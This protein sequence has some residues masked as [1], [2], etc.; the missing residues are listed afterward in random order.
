MLACRLWF[1]LAFVITAVFTLS[2]AAPARAATVSLGVAQQH[3]SLIASDN[4][5]RSNQA[6]IAGNWTS[7]TMNLTSNH[8]VPASLGADGAA[9]YSGTT[10]PNDQYSKA[11][12]S[13][14][15]TAGA[16]HGVGLL[17]RRSTSA[18]T[19]YRLVVDHASTGNVTLSKAIAG[20]A[21]TLVTLT[22][23]WSDGDVWELRVMGTTLQIRR[24]DVQ[25]GA[26]VID[27]SIASGRAGVAYAAT[28]S[29]ASVDDWEGGA[30]AKA[31]PHEPAGFTAFMNTDFT[32]FPIDEWFSN[33]ATIVT[34]STAPVSS[35]FQVVQWEYETS[36]NAGNSPGAIY[37]EEVGHT[38]DAYFVGFHFKFSD[39]YSNHANG[40]SMWWP[41][42]DSASYVIVFSE[43]STIGVQVTVPDSTYNLEGNIANPTLAL[44]VWHQFEH[45]FQP[46]SSPTADDGIIRWWIDGVLCGDYTDIAWPGPSQD[47]DEWRYYPIWGGTGGHPAF[48]SYQWVDRIY[49]SQR[50]HR[51]HV[52]GDSLLATD[53][54]DRADQ[55]PLAGNWTATD[56]TPLD[57]VSNH[58]RPSTLV[59]D[60]GAYYSAIAWPDDQYSKANLSVRGTE[61]E[62][63]GVG[64]LVRQSATAVTHY[65]LVVDHAESGNVAIDKAIDGDYTNLATFT[66]EW[67]DGDEWE[68]R[69]VGPTLQ[70]FRNGNQVGTNITDYAIASGSAG[71]VYSSTETSAA[72][73]NWEGGSAVT[74]GPPEPVAT[75]IDP[76]VATTLAASTA[77]LY[78]GEHPVQTG[79]DSGTIDPVRVA[80]LRGRVID[81]SGTP[82][83]G[84]AVSFLDHP[85]FGQTL[86][87]A[88][89]G[90]DLAANGGGMLTLTYALT[91]YL[92]A[93][94]PV[95]TRGQ[96]YAP[97]F[98]V[99]LVPLDTAV[100][101]IAFSD[102]IEVARG[103]V[104]T[105]TNGARQ[106]TLLFRQGTT[107]ML[108][109]PDTTLTIDTLHVRATE[110]T[111]G[112]RGAQA[113]PAPLP[114]TVAYT[115]A[116]ELS[117]DEAV[118]AGATSVGFSL[119][120][121]FY[122]E[123]F[124][125]FPVGVPVPVGSYDRARGVWVPEDNGR[126]IKIL[127]TTGDTATIDADGDSLPDDSTQLAA[128]GVTV[129][130]Q[131][132]LAGLY[133]PGQTLWRVQTAHFTTMDFNYGPGLCTGAGCPPQ[134]PGPPTSI[135]QKDDCCEDGGSIVESQNQ[136]LGETIEVV[137]TPFSLN[138][139]SD[140]VPG[141]TSAYRLDIPLTGSFVASTVAALW[142]SEQVAGRTFLDS[143]EAAPD[144]STTFTW[145]GLDAYGRPM[146]GE[147]PVTVDIWYRLEPPG[148]RWG[149]SR[150]GVAR[151][152]GRTATIDPMD[153]VGVAMGG[154]YWVQEGWSH[155]EWE[156]RLGVFDFQ[157]LGLG[158]WAL[159]VQ[160]V[161]DPIGH[162]LYLGTGERRSTA[163]RTVAAHDSRVVAGNG[164]EDYT[165]D[166]GPATEASLKSATA[167]AHAP[168]GSFYIL[169]RAAHVV[170]RVGV[171]GVIQTVA[172]TGT[173]GFA[174]DSGPAAEAQLDDPA[175]IALAPDGSL[176]IADR[177]NFR[178]RR[179]DPTGTITTVAG[180]GD[181][182]SSGDD[183]PAIAADLVGPVA[184]ANAVDGSLYIADGRAIRQLTTDGFIAT[185]AGN[186][187]TTGCAGDSIPAASSCFV[188]DIRHIAVGPDA[189]LYVLEGGTPFEG[190]GRIRQINTDGMIKTVAGDTTEVCLQGA[191][192]G[193]PAIEAGLCP[194]SFGF[195]ADGSIIV[196]DLGDQLRAFRVGGPIGQYWHGA[197]DNG[198][199]DVLLPALPRRPLLFA[200]RDVRT[201]RVQEDF[202]DCVHS[203][204]VGP[205]DAL[206][207]GDQSTFQVRL[208]E[209]PL[210]DFA[211]QELQI[212]AED[213]SEVFVFDPQ[214]RHLSTRDAL[215]GS[216]RWTFGYDT[217]GKI[218][219][220]TD[221]DSNITTIER[222]STGA[223][224]GIV[225][226]L[227][228]RTTVALDS[229]GYLA[230]V[231]NP[232]GFVTTLKYA[233]GGLLDTL[234]DARGYVHQFTYDSLGLLVK[235]KDAAGDS[236]ML[237]RT[238]TATGYE[239]T[240][241][242]A[243]GRVKRY[244]EDSLEAG[245][246]QST[247]VGPDG[248][249][250]VT[251]KAADGTTTTDSPDGTR[252]VTSFTADPRFGM[253]AP[254]LDS[255]TVRLPSSVQ[256]TIRQVRHDSLANP[257][258]PLSLVTQIDSVSFNGNTTVTS[259][260]AAT[261]RFVQTS[262]E[263]R[264]LVSRLEGKGRT[265]SA[266]VG[267]LDSVTFT[268]DTVGRV[269]QEQQGGRITSY[270]YHSANGRLAS[271]TD[272]LGRITRFDY[273]SA[274]RITRQT[275]PDSSV[276]VFAYDSS[277]N[278]TRL[279]PPGRPA[280]TFQYT[281]VDLVQRYDPP[282]VPDSTPTR[283]FYNLERQLD[284]IVR[285]DSITVVFRYDS[286]GRPDSVTFDRGTLTYGYEPSTGRL[287]AIRA[288]NGDSLTFAYDGSLTSQASWAGTVNG[289]VQIG[290]NNDV[291][292]ASQT[293]N[294]T[295]E[296]DFLYD[297]D[298][299]L[300]GAG[301]LVLGRSTSNGLLL[302]D[303]LGL[304]R[305][306]YQYTSRGELAGYRV[307]YDTTKLF[308]T[309]YARD[310]VGRIVQLFDTI[311]G[312]PTR[313]RFIYDSVG[314]LIADSV[315]GAIFH[316]FAYDSNGNRQ[317]VT[318]SGGTVTYA[319]D[320]QDRLLNA[321]HSL[322]TTIYTYGSNG[323]LRVRTATGVGT[324][325]YTYDAFGNLVTVLLPDST[326]IDYVID[327]QNRRVGRKVNG[328]LLQAW[329]YQN[330]LSPLA[331]LD[332]TGMVVSRFVYGSRANAPDYMVKD[333]NVY[334]FVVDHLGSVRLVVDTATGTIAQR[335]DYD[336]WG[337]VTQ[338]TSPGFQPFGFAGGIWD[339]STK[340]LRFGARDY[341]PLVGRW[342]AK[343]PIRFGAGDF[344]LYTYA[345]GDPVNATDRTGLLF[346]G[347][348]NAGECAGED[349]ARFWANRAAEESNPLLAGLD[350]FMG[351]LASLWTPETS[352]Y[353]F[354]V[355]STAVGGVSR[356]GLRIERGAWGPRPA[357]KL[358]HFHWGE[359]L[360][361]QSHHLPYQ[362]GDWLANFQSL[363]RQGK[364]G[365]DLTNIG[366]VGAGGL[367]ALLN[368][369][370]V[371]LGPCP[372]GRN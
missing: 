245:G 267:D 345:G 162:T 263:G 10:W 69:V 98:D 139:R 6:P 82:L 144:L 182:A 145:D 372:C 278:L 371:G 66:E 109:L 188:S 116:V 2:P 329:L 235:D 249:P 311:Q 322:D 88:N 147:Q 71:L 111:V 168:D 216:A 47:W 336:E 3:D 14:T 159:S 41:F 350:N 86:S 259:Y 332:S 275:R 338:N 302:A 170:R 39:P 342:T 266:R 62:E 97:L 293:V 80:V 233:T 252:T 190:G 202:I 214:G 94:R 227:G 210:P 124:L 276:T 333:G 254:V 36:L 352:D 13:V 179:V 261:R 93:Q 213:G 121:A 363:V 331:E 197:C 189:R 296:V 157:A 306:A 289:S 32:T 38:V 326:V 226:P 319:Y 122:M 85:E 228:Q 138:Y 325:R 364:A 175:D 131:V 292:V 217:L 362:G 243:L 152:W 201:L 148:C 195:A 99:V 225:G 287:T 79:V 198:H 344:G 368:K 42:Q 223:P 234:V 271:V 328:V 29:A 288:P 64:L 251:T 128:L 247:F 143:M 205:N 268:Y 163:G 60:G 4:F 120:V 153:C 283:Y 239:V 256:A 125:E 353:T 1:R 43:D 177:G 151:S 301:A 351:G 230:S 50:G 27:S 24:N 55:S 241:T 108:V 135:E 164:A 262:P 19:H 53:N 26:D 186:D 35:T 40:T 250:T 209:V 255:M 274:G 5:N 101:T 91:G 193:G 67:T 155:G 58:V 127:S 229:T 174:G 181:S 156:G 309:G 244:P 212:A 106:A 224:T 348:I 167:M 316:A 222:D 327:G 96:D 129:A 286:A 354:A 297:S 12:L 46:A 323:E 17:V 102:P 246:R 65:W 57:L 90:Y 165:G 105:D 232:A 37:S 218:V 7:T 9:Y 340:L 304:V 367:A 158:G 30:A 140:R 206:Y 313:W 334:R 84:V 74:A 279:T 237:A 123:N 361:L 337:N 95:A 22:Q 77:F 370:G 100:A 307:K 150:T 23:S 180:T 194:S 119:P 15:G 28:E 161:Y 81:R 112:P 273:D 44:G 314:R 192:N 260:T 219:S 341:D 87:R 117:A 308:T 183:G 166:D 280:H 61:A 317:S 365:G 318:S 291:R 76:T 52:N 113:M 272:P 220:V 70:A 16:T 315:N 185:V 75:A 215:T 221:A 264:Q 103:T 92:P 56:P 68:L 277:G 303:T 136:T 211:N 360:G 305:S 33:G 45:Y 31:W 142:V 115:Y 312:T 207:V 240:L 282:G 104:Q 330:Q 110:Y 132:A 21:T 366:I 169:D 343:D 199:G 11:K 51:S 83:S 349:A 347:L 107:A 137:G 294:G 25:V 126:V 54:F 300:T 204:V 242:S 346:G 265:V 321:V 154:S 130:E 357:P 295:N 257:T 141:R 236:L 18:T 358:W 298:G 187:T 310:S 178:V 20:T 171:D 355:L 290:Y 238:T 8:V 191:G 196:A 149:R 73:D 133:A 118:E 248:L 258:D 285:P 203:L 184:L 173:P 253:Q 49:V 78:T 369:L 89:G 359:G 48:T 134:P 200:S 284:S 114:P 269:A 356:A 72:I 34:D 160:H 335:I 63:R 59:T 231:S 299:A 176:Y 146:Q 172:G 281:A 339:D 320:N 324:T 270:A 208:R